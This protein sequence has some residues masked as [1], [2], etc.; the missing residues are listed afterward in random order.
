MPVWLSV[1]SFSFCAH[2]IGKPVMAPEP[3]AAPASAAP[4]LMTVRRVS[5]P[6]TLSGR[7]VSDLVMSAS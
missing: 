6:C 1:M 4:P 7:S 5:D 2:T 3:A